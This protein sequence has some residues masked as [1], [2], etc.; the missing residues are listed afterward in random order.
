[1]LH[2]IR[3]HELMLDAREMAHP[4]PFEKSTA[5]LLTL[6]QGEYLRM[7]HWR[8]PYPLFEFCKARKLDFIVNELNTDNYEIIFFFASDIKALT[9]QCVLAEHGKRISL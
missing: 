4:E 8:I 1:M 3:L 2:E 7:L 6:N 9:E 5:I